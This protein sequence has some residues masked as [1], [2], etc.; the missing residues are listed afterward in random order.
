MRPASQ[1]PA[2]PWAV[3]FAVGAFLLVA[4][5]FGV[6]ASL[7]LTVRLLLGSLAGFSAW[8]GVSALSDRGR[9]LIALSLGQAVVL[10]LVSAV[11]V[12]AA[13]SWR[14]P[15]A[16][17]IVGPCAY[18]ATRLFALWIAPD[19]RGWVR[20]GLRAE[21]FLTMLL[22][23]TS[24]V[25]ALP[26]VES[27]RP[28]YSVL[29]AVSAIAISVVLQR[30]WVSLNHSG[31]GVVGVVGGLVLLRLLKEATGLATL[32]LTAAP[33]ACWPGFA[34]RLPEVM[35]ALGA[36]GMRLLST[37]AEVVFLALFWIRPASR[38]ELPRA[39]LAAAFLLLLGGVFWLPF[40]VLDDRLRVLLVLASAAVAAALRR[41]P[42]ATAAPL[43]QVLVLASVA[44]K[45]LGELG[46]PV[47]SQLVATTVVALVGLVGA[48][49]VGSRPTPA[50]LTFGLALACTVPS[51]GAET[52]SLGALVAVL[53]AA[54]LWGCVHQNRANGLAAVALALVGAAL[55]TCCVLAGS[56]WWG[57]RSGVDVSLTDGQI[58]AT[59]AVTLVLAVGGVGLVAAASGWVS[60]R[61]IADRPDTALP[62]PRPPLPDDGG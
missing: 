6:L 13:Q 20:L 53:L 40:P 51:C 23:T 7:P 42:A 60:T 33:V 57:L 5:S 4:G 58:Q 27:R 61:A 1:N 12:W 16:L 10:P 9:A 29:P 28:E 45:V 41:R 43:L 21:L 59:W 8:A 25:L 35:I 17:A 55:A 26:S 24:W 34:T 49:R 37:C 52:W 19:D 2:P 38:S 14:A 36:S 50:Q 56:V 54:V 47:K 15:L 39:E 48:L 32:G 30:Q 44:A 11:D 22:F 18:I 31:G 46:V 3:G 62:D